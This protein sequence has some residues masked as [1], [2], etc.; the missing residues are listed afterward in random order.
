MSETPVTV[1]TISENII[2]NLL[3]SMIQDIVSREIVKQKQLQ[4]RYPDMKP[5]HYDPNGLLDFNGLP[6]Q[7]ES[8]QY[9]HCQNCNREISA[10]RFAAHL[11]RCLNRGSRR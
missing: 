3:H 10:N 11:Q 2:G 7:Q 8:S 4:A 1:E 9:F 6:K 5:Y